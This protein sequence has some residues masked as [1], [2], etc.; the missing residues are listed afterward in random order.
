MKSYKNQVLTCI[1]NPTPVR[2]RFLNR[3][4][5]LNSKESGWTEIIMIF[6]QKKSYICKQYCC[7]WVTMNSLCVYTLIL[8]SMSGF[9]SNFLS[10]S[11]TTHHSCQFLFPT[12]S[13]ICT[14][15]NSLSL[16]GTTHNPF[17]ISFGFSRESRD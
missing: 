7:W 14:P 11:G 5:I 17:V 8:L 10:R 13:W 6:F 1:S 15:K 16:E 2:D 12:P 9:D 3:V 4:L